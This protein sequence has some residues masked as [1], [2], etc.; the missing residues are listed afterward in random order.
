MIEPLD[1]DRL[2][3]SQHSPG[4]LGWA[5]FLQAQQHLVEMLVFAYTCTS[6]TRPS[7]RAASAAK[8]IR[9]V[10]SDSAGPERMRP[11]SLWATAAT[12]LAITPPSPPPC[13]LRIEPSASLFTSMRSLLL[14]R[15][16]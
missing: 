15:K 5:P 1:E 3:T 16:S 13:P 6:T 8:T 7:R 11:G 12:K 4:K 10:S 9:W 14:V 2:Q